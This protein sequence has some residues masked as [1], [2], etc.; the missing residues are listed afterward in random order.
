MWGFLNGYAGGSPDGVKAQVHALLL[1]TQCAS[2]G[3]VVLAKNA[4]SDGL[5]KLVFSVY[6]NAFGLI[7]LIPFAFFYER[8]T[9]LP[10]TLPVLKKYTI[11]GFIGVYL[12]QFLFYNGLALTNA[13]F[14]SAMQ[15]LTP[16]FTLIIAAIY[17]LEVITWRHRCG[18]AKIV[19]VITSVSGAILMTCYKGPP[20]LQLKS[21]ATAGQP[22]E[23]LHQL[24]VLRILAD[25][26]GFVMEPWKLGALC[27]VGNCFCC[28][29]F[30][31]VQSVTLAKHRAPVSLAASVFSIG[32]IM[33]AV[34]GLILVRDPKEWIV[35]EPSSV[36]AIV[37]AGAILSCL[38]VGAIAWSISKTGPVLAASYGPLQAVATAILAVIFLKETFYL[39]SFIGSVL[40]ILGLYLINWGQKTS[41]SALEALSFEN[42][43]IIYSSG[44]LK[45]PLLG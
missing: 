7:L 19:G 22:P 3:Y 12:N 9:R 28:A 36:I 33:L 42:Q 16:V 32:E 21:T 35:S 31:N 13:T 34:T 38:A 11:L 37:Y 6:R 41:N 45:E 40:I 8:N 25:V 15:I 1:V 44:D 30:I 2:G 4:L 10:L 18:Q 43:V 17:R 39:G 5:H 27:L 26:F 14:A 29:S 20:L 23:L 24:L